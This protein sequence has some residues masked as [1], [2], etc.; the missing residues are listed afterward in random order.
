MFDPDSTNL[1][2]HIKLVL[3]VNKIDKGFLVA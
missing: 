3:Y 2:Q 1:K